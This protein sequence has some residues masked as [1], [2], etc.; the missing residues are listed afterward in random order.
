MHIENLRVRLITVLLLV[1]AVLAVGFSIM[2]MTSLSKAET[3]FARENLIRLHVIA[4]S[5]SPADQDLKLLVRDAV[6]SETRAVFAQVSSK[7]EAQRLLLENQER[8]INAAEHVIREQGYDYS[9]S[10][11][12]GNYLFPSRT[13]GD[14]T[15]PA[16]EY[17][18][19]QI[20]IGE[21][22]G[23]N[24][25]CVLFPPLCLGELEADSESQN[26][27]KINRENNGAG[28]AFRFKLLEY[29]QETR[30]AEGLRRW[31]QASAAGL[32]K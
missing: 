5:D 2:G 25:W 21:A 13:Y 28:I 14:L 10:L 23:A 31:W 15:L 20:R 27:V 7:E 30:Y 1:L 22:K 11:H 24:W 16:G 3:A 6:L 12:T 9:V 8:V 32:K 4:N 26:L 19:V 18:A 17:D 29:V